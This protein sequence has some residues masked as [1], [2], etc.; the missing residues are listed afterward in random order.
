MLDGQQKLL[1]LTVVALDLQADVAQ[2]ECESAQMRL[3]IRQSV[4]ELHVRGIENELALLQQ[5]GRV[6]ELRLGLASL[7]IPQGQCERDRAREAQAVLST[8]PRDARGTRCR[9]AAAGKYGQR[10]AARQGQ[11]DS[12]EQRRSG[13]VGAQRYAH[14]AHVAGGVEAHIAKRNG[15]GGR[16]C[17][18]QIVTEQMQLGNR[19]AS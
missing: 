17:S 11:S 10:R 19:T 2:G 13:K 14:A 7:R 4:L 12:A 5:Q 6:G 18:G 16:G 1:R 3:A 9:G 15:R 8:A